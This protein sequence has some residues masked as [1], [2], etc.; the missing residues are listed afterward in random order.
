MGRRVWFDS[1]MVVVVL[2]GVERR[3]LVDVCLPLGEGVC[4]QLSCMAVV[5]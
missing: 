4:T 5:V 2:V 1:V 3:V